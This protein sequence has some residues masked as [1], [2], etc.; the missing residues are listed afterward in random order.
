M[1]LFYLLLLAASLSI[2]HQALADE[3]QRTAALTVDEVLAEA[4]AASPLV[5]QIDSTLAGKIGD[6]IAIRILPNPALD[7]D[8]RLPGSYQGSRPETEV[9]VA[10]EQPFR[11]THFGLR[12][13]VAELISK[14]GHSDQKIALLELTQKVRLLYAR[15]WALDAQISVVEAARKRASSVATLI[16]DSSNRGLLPTSDAKLFEAV[17]KKLAAETLGLESELSRARAELTRVVGIDLAERKFGKPD[18]LSVVDAKDLLARAESGEI[19]AQQRAKLMA[20][21]ASEQSRLAQRDSFPML[22]PRLLYQHTA[23]GEEQYGVGISIELPIF[24]RNQAE[25]V[26]RSA[27]A[28]VATTEQRYFQGAAFKSQLSLLVQSLNAAIG[29]VKIYEN[30]VVPAL[31]EALGG[32]DQQLRAGQGS[33]VQVFQTQ[34]ELNDAASKVVELWVRALTDKAELSVLT[35]TDL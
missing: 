11:L 17:S 32:A 18:L 28:N 10:L 19:P 22:A 6:S 3:E 29:Q 24:D 27:E 12:N 7:I 14:A 25:R 9:E 31:Q 1:K 33:V 30:Q 21:L 8:V 34:R 13:A 26:R 35:G 2:N 16:A 15:A 20:Q 4:L 23:E 5:K